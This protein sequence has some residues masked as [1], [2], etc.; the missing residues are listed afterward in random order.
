[1]VLLVILVEIISIYSLFHLVS[2]TKL[3]I[4]R[5][6]GAILGTFFLLIVGA[7]IYRPL[8]AVVLMGCVSIYAYR[9]KPAYINFG[10][11]AAIM[12]FAL[13]GNL[14]LWLHTPG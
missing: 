1:M 3:N 12:A 11:T 6:L 9:L 8:S 5:V 13:L 14:H 2:G 7:I 10:L 4:V